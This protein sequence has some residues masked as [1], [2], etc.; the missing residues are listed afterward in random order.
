MERLIKPPLF[1]ISASLQNSE[2]VI[3]PPVPEVNEG[4][5][6]CDLDRSESVI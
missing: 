3:Q 1:K 2:I 6:V 4:V 5:R